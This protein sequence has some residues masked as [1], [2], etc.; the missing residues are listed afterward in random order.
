MTHALLTV[1]A[2]A[3]MAQRR[4]VAD[5]ALLAGFSLL[6]VVSG[7]A[8]RCALPR[9][10]P[11]TR[12]GAPKAE[13]GSKASAKA[14]AVGGGAAAAVRLVVDWGASC[15]AAAVVR[16]DKGQWRLVASAGDE[17][18]GG[19]NMDGHVARRLAVQLGTS[20]DASAAT[21]LALLTSA[22]GLKHLL[23]DAGR[24]GMQGAEELEV[25]TPNPYP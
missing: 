13:G 8:A 5:A 10:S 20:L 19:M 11:S 16:F 6:G 17:S 18:L 2:H 9:R 15:C 14:A 12:P 3:G 4:A 1:P 7:A 22:R 25:P 21:K 23:L 24:E